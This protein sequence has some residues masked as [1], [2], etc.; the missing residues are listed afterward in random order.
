MAETDEKGWNAL[1][2]AL[3]GPDKSGPKG[4]TPARHEIVRAPFSYFQRAPLTHR[5]TESAET[6]PEIETETETEIA[7]RAEPERQR[8]RE[9]ERQRGRERQR[10]SGTNLAY[11]ATRRLWYARY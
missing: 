3:G 4:D 10:E 8:S 6:E 2:W 11:S 7:R 1:F 9:A 5:E